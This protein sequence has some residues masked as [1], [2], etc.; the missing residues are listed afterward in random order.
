MLDD[1]EVD[2]VVEFVESLTDPALKD[3]PNTL[4]P[5]TIPS[6]LPIDM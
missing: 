3:L 2:L 6:E 1:T 5:V 4:G